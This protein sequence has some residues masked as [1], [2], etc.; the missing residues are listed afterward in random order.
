MASTPHTLRTVIFF[1]IYIGW[2]IALVVI[3]AILGD[4]SIRYRQVEC[5]SYNPD[6]TDQVTVREYTTNDLFVTSLRYSAAPKCGTFMS[7]D[8]FVDLIVNALF[9]SQTCAATLPCTCWSD[10]INTMQYDPIYARNIFFALMASLLGTVLGVHLLAWY[11]NWWLEP[12]PTVLPV[13]N[14]DRRADPSANQN[15]ATLVALGLWILWCLLMLVGGL[16]VGLRNNQSIPGTC[17]R[18][19]HKIYSNNQQDSYWETQFIPLEYV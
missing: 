14:A 15:S 1:W 8:F 9:V 13:R 6:A 12:D 4:I 7:F 2:A 10:A 3:G 17:D 16:V 18:F 5:V 19:R 11:L